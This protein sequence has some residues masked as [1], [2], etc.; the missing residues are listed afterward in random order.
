MIRYAPRAVLAVAVLL[1]VIA[2][3]M[4]LGRDTTRVLGSNGVPRA[5]FATTVPPGQAACERVPSVP[6][7]TRAIRLTVGVYGDTRARLRADAGF[8]ADGRV[9]HARDG[10]L[11]LP[12]ADAGYADRI[13]VA[14]LGTGRVELAGFTTP[15]ASAAVVGTTPAKG[16]FGVLYLRGPAATWGERTS[17]VLSRIGFSKGL[18]GG[19]GLGVLLV[20]LLLATVG[21]ALTLTWKVTRP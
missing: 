7:A 11:E 21:G 2:T 15:A 8:K 12:L 5:E 10:E 17:D 14:N 16:A 3:V 18:P 4:T 19:S 9:I 20:L 6:P 1:L 13:C